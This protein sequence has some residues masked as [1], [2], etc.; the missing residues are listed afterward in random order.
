MPIKVEKKTKGMLVLEL[1]GHRHTLPNLLRKELWKDSNVTLAAYEKEHM[2]LGNAKLVIRG[3]NPK[4]SLLAAITR[5][6]ASLKAF[7]ADVK[8]LK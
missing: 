3:K 4:K 6:D 1:E 7:E 5:A 2:L 8:K